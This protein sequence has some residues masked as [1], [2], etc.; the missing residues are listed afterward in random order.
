[1]GQK[2]FKTAVYQPFTVNRTVA[3]QPVSNYGRRLRRFLGFRACSHTGRNPWSAWGWAGGAGV[4]WD[5]KGGKRGG[6]G[7]RCWEGEV[8]GGNKGVEGEQ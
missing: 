4:G 6:V 1:M 8:R 2:R 7:K 5:G 3:G